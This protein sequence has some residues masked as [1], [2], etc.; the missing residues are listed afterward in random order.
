M[1]REMYTQYPRCEKVKLNDNSA[2]PLFYYLLIVPVRVNQM[3]RN[4][5]K[6]WSS[7][8]LCLSVLKTDKKDKA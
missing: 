8:E 7:Y 2:T 1:K 6:I 5:M 4:K 3:D